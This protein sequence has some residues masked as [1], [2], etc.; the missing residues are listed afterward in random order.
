MVFFVTLNMSRLTHHRKDML[1]EAHARAQAMVSSFA[2]VAETVGDMGME[3]VALLKKASAKQRDQV[4][5]KRAKAEFK[6]AYAKYTK[7]V[8]AKVKRDQAARDEE[9]LLEQLEKQ[10][11]TEAQELALQQDLE[12][13]LQRTKREAEKA[14]LIAENAEQSDGEASQQTEISNGDEDEDDDFSIDVVEQ[15]RMAEKFNARELALDAAWN[16]PYVQVGF[17]FCFTFGS[18]SFMWALNRIIF[19]LRFIKVPN[20]RASHSNNTYWQYEE[21]IKLE[22]ARPQCQGCFPQPPWWFHGKPKPDR[23]HLLDKSEGVFIV[24]QDCFHVHSYQSLSLT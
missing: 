17:V 5:R 6:A 11:E 24:L 12:A 3:L 18:S 21:L 9:L 20:V 2:D 8:Y 1:E 4:Q 19:L 15:R 16:K 14:A 10:R 23:V 13:Q 22:N 7:L